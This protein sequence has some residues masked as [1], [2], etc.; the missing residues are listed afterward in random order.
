V[1]GKRLAGIRALVAAIR[2]HQIAPHEYARFTAPVFFSRG[3][4]THPRWAAMQERLGLL[5]PDF[6]GRSS[7]DSITSTRRIKRSRLGRAEPHRGGHPE[8]ISGCRLRD[9]NLELQVGIP[10]EL[11]VRDTRSGRLSSL[12]QGVQVVLGLRKYLLV[13]SDPIGLL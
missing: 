11:A 3:S 9:G 7:K 12:H 1:D 10:A 4:R 6:T 13:H 2:E 8:S 5:F